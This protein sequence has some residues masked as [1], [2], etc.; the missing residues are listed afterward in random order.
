MTSESGSTIALEIQMSG[1]F[2]GSPFV[3]V[4]NIPKAMNGTMA[5][6]LE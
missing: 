1:Q 4:L 3:Y 2:W 6:R 5:Y